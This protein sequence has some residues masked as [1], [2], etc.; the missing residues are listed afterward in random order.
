MTMSDS[1]GWGHPLLDARLPALRAG[2]VMLVSQTVRE[3]GGI[4]LRIAAAELC[5]GGVV[6]WV[7]GGSRFDPSRLSPHVAWRR[8]S[9]REALPRLQVCRGF[10]AH[11]V[12]AQVG[13]MADG[14]T[15]GRLVIVSDLSRMFADP[16]VGR[17]EGRS[18]MR[19]AME[20]LRRLAATGVAVVV[21]DS[22]RASPGTRPDQRLEQEAR[23]DRLLRSRPLRVG[24][25]MAP[26]VALRLEDPRIDVLWRALP[27]NQ[28]CLLDFPAFD[29]LSRSGPFGETTLPAGGPGLGQPCLGPAEGREDGMD[30]AQG[31]GSV[32]GG[33]A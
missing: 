15:A 24:R 26:V 16:Q 6:H 20:A 13:R 17:A 27:W 8:G 10:T 12:A 33:I 4:L 1:I 21:S 28:S 31:E 29:P 5:E 11:Q 7:D 25:R 30:R 32:E 2:E 9:I 22:R 14:V 18:M 23:A 19:R 3:C